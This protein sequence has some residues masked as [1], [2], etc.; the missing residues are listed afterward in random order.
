MAQTD[1]SRV[2]WMN[3][4]LRSSLD[5]SQLPQSHRGR[6]PVGRNCQGALPSA[7]AT[8]RQGNRVKSRQPR[9]IR[10]A[11]AFAV[12]A[13]ALQKLPILLD[14]DLTPDEVSADLGTHSESLDLRAR[15]RT[16]AFPICHPWRRRRKSLS[17]AIG[18]Y[19]TST[20]AARITIR[21]LAPFR[22]R[23]PRTHR[24]SHG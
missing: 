14:A 11:Q 8:P 10:T 22:F 9:K 1:P 24:S 3:S 4:L 19:G 21:R 6:C 17:P 7:A 12:G 15:Q 20:R 18:L 2:L 5:L 13:Y 23:I 16:R